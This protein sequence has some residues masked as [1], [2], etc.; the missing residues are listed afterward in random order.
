[1]AKTVFEVLVEKITDQKRSSEEFIRTGAAKDY[2]AY[3]EICGVLR[4]LDTALREI[5]DLS[6]IHMENQDD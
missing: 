4:G 2:A 1:M 3:K 6:R 5:N